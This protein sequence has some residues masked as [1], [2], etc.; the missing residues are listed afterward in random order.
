MVNEIMP[1]NTPSQLDNLPVWLTVA[2][3]QDL[4]RLSRPT[5]IG[6]L[7][8]GVIPGKKCG[9]QWRVSKRRLAEVMDALDSAGRK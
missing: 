7:Q 6:L 1:V 5:V 9:R 8:G 3:V 4:L 2:E